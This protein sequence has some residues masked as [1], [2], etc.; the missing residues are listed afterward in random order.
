MLISWQILDEDYTGSDE[1]ERIKRGIADYQERFGIEYVMLVGDAHN[2]PVRYQITDRPQTIQD[3]LVSVGAYYACDLYYADLYDEDGNFDTWD[4]DGNRYY[5]ELWGEHY[6]GPIN[7]DRINMIPDVALGRVPASSE[8]E[9]TNY[10]NKVIHY[11]STGVTETWISNILFIV[12]T[13]DF[14]TFYEHKE[15]IIDSYSGVT[16][17]YNKPTPTFWTMYSEAVSST[18]D[19]EPGPANINDLM[20]THGL[21]LIN[22]GGHGGA[23]NEVTDQYYH[24]SMSGALGTWDLRDLTTQ[25]YPIVFSCGCSNGRFTVSPAGDPYVD[26]AGVAHSGTDWGEIFDTAAYPPR[27]DPLQPRVCPT[28]RDEVDSFGEY[29]TCRTEFWFDGTRYDIRNRGFIAFIGCVTG[30]Q[31]PIGE[32]DKYFLEAFFTYEPE[33]R[34]GDLWNHAVERYCDIHGYGRG[35]YSKTAGNWVDVAKYHMPMK[36]CLFGDPSLRVGGI[37]NVPPSPEIEPP[38]IPGLK[39]FFVYAGGNFMYTFRAHDPGADSLTYTVDFGDG[40]DEIVET[41]YNEAITIYH[42]YGGLL[43]PTR[44]YTI[45]L[46]VADDYGGVGSTSI[47][48]QTVPNPLGLMAYRMAEMFRVGPEYGLPILTIIVTAPAIFSLVSF[49]KLPKWWRGCPRSARIIIPLLP[50]LAVIA[51]LIGLA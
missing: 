27:P 39:R 8:A 25:R 16:F 21:G 7:H 6:S 5:G 23:Y 50:I 51:L 11:E 35:E 44:E 26:E 34:L 18:T 40:S 29:G 1:P 15:E 47:T 41:T 10:V 42:R 45:Q 28:G 12:T 2:F 3:V 33:K 30:A 32:L 14:P 13:T 20:N 22:F 36:V 4:Y 37:Y 48:I 38:R 19:Y 31:E 43:D 49:I 46:T 17:L 9:V 24:C